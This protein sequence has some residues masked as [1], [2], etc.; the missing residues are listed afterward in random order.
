LFDF[1]FT[2]CNKNKLVSVSKRK[3]LKLKKNV[4]I[5][6]NGSTGEYPYANTGNRL[7]KWL[8]EGITDPYTIHVKKHCAT[9]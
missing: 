7:V 2:Y 9:A 6:N 3:I 1:S 4:I 5:F 8:D